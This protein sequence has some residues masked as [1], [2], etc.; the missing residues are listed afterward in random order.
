MRK[1]LRSAL[2][3][4][5]FIYAWIN[6]KLKFYFFVLAA[7]IYKTQKE[8]IYYSDHPITYPQLT[9]AMVPC[10]FTLWATSDSSL[11]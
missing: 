5:I 7:G 6:Y 4:F 8:K 9:Q 2:F 10:P 11:R 1:N 3:T